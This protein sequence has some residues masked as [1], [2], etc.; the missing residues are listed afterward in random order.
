MISELAAMR[1]VKKMTDMKTNI[2]LY[3]LMKKGMKFR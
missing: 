1:D 3:M 2:A